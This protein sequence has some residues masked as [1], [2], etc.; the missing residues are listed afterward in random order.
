MYKKIYCD[1]K[2]TLNS[3]RVIFDETIAYKNKLEDF[4]IVLD[5][6]GMFGSYMLMVILL[7]VSLGIFFSSWFIM[8]SLKNIIEYDL[9]FIRLISFFISSASMVTFSTMLITKTVKALSAKRYIITDKALYMCGK[10]QCRA[11]RIPYARLKSIKRECVKK[12][13]NDITKNLYEAEVLYTIPSS[14]VSITS[15]ITVV[16]YIRSCENLEKI[17]DY[18]E[19][20]K[21]GRLNMLDTS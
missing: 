10:N 2:R 12:D 3:E 21:N 4:G 8:P 16:T 20:A 13:K 1:L 5:R 7:M 11:E 15:G 14:D 18:I 6:R 9:N 17:C 19:A